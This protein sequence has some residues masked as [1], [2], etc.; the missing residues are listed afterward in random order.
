MKAWNVD[1]DGIGYLVA[2]RSSAEALGLCLLLEADA[3]NDGI[4]WEKHRVWEQ[5][6]TSKMLGE[7]GVLTEPLSALLARVGSGAESPQV[8]GCS[9]W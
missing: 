8:I 1:V 3:G 9:E 7:D 2:A 5:E 4:N 6:D